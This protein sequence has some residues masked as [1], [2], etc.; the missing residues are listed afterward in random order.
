MVYKAHGWV[1]F[2]IL[3]TRSHAPITPKYMSNCNHREI[4][5]DYVEKY[6]RCWPSTFHIIIVEDADGWCQNWLV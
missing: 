3:G 2:H 5:G 1:G 6:C 4:A